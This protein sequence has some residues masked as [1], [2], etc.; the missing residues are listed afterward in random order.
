MALQLL[1][2][3]GAVEEYEAGR[4][5]SPKA[6][7]VA[8]NLFPPFGHYY[9]L[10]SQNFV[11]VGPLHRELNPVTPYE[12]GDTSLSVNLSHFRVMAWLLYV[13]V[14]LICHEFIQEHRYWTPVGQGYKYNPSESEKNWMRMFLERDDV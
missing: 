2:E 8:K 5:K 6:V 1:I 9:G 4:L 13:S 14:E 7:S 12:P 10:L 3:P 11:H